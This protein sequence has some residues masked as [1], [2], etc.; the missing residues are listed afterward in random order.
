VD[1]FLRFREDWPRDT[2]N[3]EI[4]ANSRAGVE[5]RTGGDSVL[6]RN[7]ITDN[8]WQA[9][10]IAEGGGGTFEKNDLRGNSIGAW[11]IH[12]GCEKQVKRSEN[13]E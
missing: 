7:R 5:I 11:K 9:I 6:R 8:A 4:F 12:P 3:N 13:L 2:S 10:W 1:F